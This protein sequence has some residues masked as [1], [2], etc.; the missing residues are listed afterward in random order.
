MR[1]FTAVYA[2]SFVLSLCFAQV[3]LAEAP[4]GGDAFTHGEFSVILLAAVQ[5]DPEALRSSEDALLEI[6][7]AGLAPQTWSADA[8]LT[9][10]ELASIVVA[11]GGRYEP[12]YPEQPATRAFSE[13]LLRSQ[14][15]VLEQHAGELDSRANTGRYA[16]DFV[17]DPGVSPSN[18]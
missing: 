3:G 5:D 11:M 18:F 14:A 8:A 9:H 13:A 10:G 4:A 16:M 12:T 6:K 17:T 15:E 7:K 1:R 2:V